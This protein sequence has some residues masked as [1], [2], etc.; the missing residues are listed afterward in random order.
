M[1]KDYYKILG[2]N[3]GA[4][5]DE[6][7]KGYRKMALKYHPD[8][9][10]TTG[11]EEKFKD[12]AEAYDVL[13][14][15]KKKEIY[16]RFGEEGL[17][18]GSSGGP[19][20]SCNSQQ[21]NSHFQYQFQGDPHDIFKQFFG[22]DPFADAFGGFDFED[23][24][25]PQHGSH[26]PH[27]HHPHSAGGMPGRAQSF[28]FSSPSSSHHQHQHQHNGTTRPQ[29]PAIERDLFVTLDEVAKGCVKRMKITRRI[30]DRRS[31]KIEDKV[32]TIE[33]KKGW[34]AGTKIT[35][36]REGDQNPD[37]VPADIV[38]VLRDKPHPL[39]TRDGNDLVYMVRL[40]LKKALCGPTT[41]QVPTLDGR[42]IPINLDTVTTPKTI[43]RVLGEGLPFPKEPA[44]KGDIV[45][46]FDIDFPATL[47]PEA[48]DG[49]RRFLP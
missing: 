18:G 8:K 24:G 30:N 10:K 44:R 12:V 16:D 48:K 4:S 3:R 27:G 33:I 49:L 11:A 22:R 13:S 17:K 9:N 31:S 40:T 5:D 20:T 36:P 43:R 28:H 42:R 26:G 21:N 47:S 2:V 37:T 19:R 25:H 29:D 46:K 6:I 38:F 32:L 41:I 15:P 39:F 7:K 23:F 34:K 35:F 14:D 1:G 45:L